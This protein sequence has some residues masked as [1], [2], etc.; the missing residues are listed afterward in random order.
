MLYVYPPGTRLVVRRRY[1]RP[2][3]DPISVRAGDMVAIDR[4]KTQAT[5]LFGWLWCRGADGREGWTPEAWLE[6]VGD[7]ARIK[8][9][10][11]AL[12]LDVVEGE[13]LIALFG[14]SG[15]IFAR[16]SN[17]EEGWVPDGAVDLD[18]DQ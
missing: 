8:R 4:E 6:Q 14:E 3:R 10:F 12:E 18:L 2:Y 13:R 11:S 5:D 9:D 16:K 7:N 17:G 1:E 15:F